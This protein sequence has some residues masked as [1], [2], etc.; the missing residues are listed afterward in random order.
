MKF[1]VGIGLTAML[2]IAPAA[3]RPPDYRLIVLARVVPQ[4][5][6]YGVW[7]VDTRGRIAP[8]PYEFPVAY[9][10]SVLG[11]T[12][13]MPSPDCRWIAYGRDYDLHI[14]DVQLR[15][16]RQI[17]RFGRPPG[18]SHT[19]A[20]VL[21]NAW[22]ADSRQVLFTVA[23]GETTSESGELLVPE[24][25]Y[26]SYIYT[27]ST[28]ATKAV[29]LPK[30][31]QVTGWMPD[32]RLL[33]IVPGLKAQER[34][35]VVILG[36]DDHRGAFVK[37]PKGAL[38]HV[39]ASTDGKW[40]IGLLVGSGTQLTTAQIVKVRVSTSSVVPLVSLKSW[41]GNER[42][43]LSPDGNHVAYKLANRFLAGVPAETLFVNRRS[44]CVCPG[45]IDYQWITDRSL[46]VACQN[47]VSV[48]ESVT[49]KRISGFRLTPAPSQ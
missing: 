8:F 27:L 20:D 14:L 48:V 31:F 18:K 11:S 46:A 4:G 45:P 43:S 2:V 35:R 16:D 7:K 41:S 5:L 42:P 25:P 32:S 36:P 33:G 13:P 6:R 17:T 12:V 3:V 40:L 47:E 23:P 15:Q 34:E 10:A 26:G 44:L 21:L 19:Y 37:T 38:G 22:S 9:D 24:A 1:G 28:A 39:T 29:A 49:G 30:G